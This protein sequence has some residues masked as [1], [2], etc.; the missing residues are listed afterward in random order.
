MRKQT[1]R[2]EKLMQFRQLRILIFVNFRFIDNSNQ[3]SISAGRFEKI[4][5]RC[6]CKE[7]KKQ[8]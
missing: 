7:I 6:I 2:F 8:K 4:G 1:F 5:F 3:F